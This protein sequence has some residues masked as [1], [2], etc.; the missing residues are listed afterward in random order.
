MLDHSTTIGEMLKINNNDAKRD[1]DDNDSSSDQDKAGLNGEHV[2]VCVCVPLCL[3]V[4]VCSTKKNLSVCV[5]EWV[6]VCVCVLWRW[7]CQSVCF[8]GWILT[9]WECHRTI[10]GWTLSVDIQK[11]I[12]TCNPLLSVVG[13]RAGDHLQTA[14]WPQLSKP[15]P[16]LPSQN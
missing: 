16:L 6:R 9:C 11:A 13:I 3:C 14:H 8:C 10:S 4:C 7:V 15:P 2:C 1:D 12:C 5:G